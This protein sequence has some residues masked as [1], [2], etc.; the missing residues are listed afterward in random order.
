LGF[1]LLLV[2]GRLP[3]LEGH[4][5]LV[6]FDLLPEGSLLGEEQLPAQV[7]GQPESASPGLL[8]A[9]GLLLTKGGR[10]SNC[11]LRTA[12]LLRTHLLRAN[13][14]LTKGLLPTDGFLLIHFLPPK[15]L[16]LPKRFLLANRRRLWTEHFRFPGSLRWGRSRWTGRCS[17]RPAILLID[18]L[19]RI[20]GSRG[21]RNGQE[22]L[23]ASLDRP[24]CGF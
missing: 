18:L 15:G 8:L 23:R 20:G 21:N 9:K 11:L 14:L 24:E 17:I 13:M 19:G 6:C 22:L 10:G 1:R 3:P 4:R 12:G 2:R 5:G 16:L 7:F